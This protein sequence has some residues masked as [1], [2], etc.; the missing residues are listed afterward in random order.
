M[1][2]LEKGCSGRDTRHRSKRFEHQP[3]KNPANKLQY[4][5]LRSERTQT[6]KQVTTRPQPERH[7][8]ADQLTAFAE[9]ALSTSERAFCLK[10]LA[11]C[12]HCREIAFLAGVT[13]TT[14]ETAPTPVRSFWRFSWPT[15]SLGAATIAA[16]VIAV[17]F[18]HHPH[19][20]APAATVQIATGT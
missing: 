2:R 6:R 5:V 12:S 17:L 1:P 7:L 10:H 13:P 19:Q 16:V 15:F 4:T 11:E 14:E 20:K 18:L 9:G 8:D 3:A